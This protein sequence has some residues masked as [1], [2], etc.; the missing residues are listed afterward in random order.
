MDAMSCLNS[1]H[2][3]LVMSGCFSALSVWHE[4]HFD[5]GNV[6]H[7]PMIQ[8]SGN[9]QLGRRLI[10]MAKESIIK[11]LLNLRWFYIFYFIAGKK[12]NCVLSNFT[13]FY[14]FCFR[15]QVSKI[16]VGTLKDGPS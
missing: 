2:I 9:S 1:P 3:F 7:F 12:P 13:T 10:P 8:Q 11:V 15:K 16:A 4:F 5:N 6:I 14:L